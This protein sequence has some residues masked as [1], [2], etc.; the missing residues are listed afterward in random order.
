M[1]QFKIKK[2][3]DLPLAGEP[4]QRICNCVPP[5]SV[6]LVGYDYVGLK[7]TL[8]VKVGDRVKLG[9]VLFTDKK[10]PGVKYTAP[11]CG[12]VSSINRGP[13]R[14]FESIVIELDGDEEVTFPSYTTE[15]LTLLN[16]EAVVEQLVE[17]GLWTALRARPFGK[18]PQPGTSAH[19]IFITAM[20]TRPHA[21]SI[22]KIVRGNEEDFINGILAVSKL[23]D[24]RVYLCK[25]T[26]TVIPTA[27]LDR[28][29]VE[30]FSGP[31]PAG[32][33]GTHIHFL[34]PV[35]RN[36]TVWYI[37]AQDIMAIGRLFT[38]GRIPVNRV[39]AMSGPVVKEPRLIKTRLG[40]SID[41]MV[42]GELHDNDNRVISG[43]VL[44]GRTSAGAVKYLGRYHQQIS[45]V[46]EGRQRRFLGWLAPGW[47]LFSLKNIV[48]SKLVPGKRFRFTT[49][50][51]GGVRAIMPIGCYEKVMPLDILPVFL[52]RALAIDD[53]EEAE[54]LGCLELEEED[55]A[56]CT[57]ASPA[58]IDYGP[59]LRR[60]LT[61]IEKEG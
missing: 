43:S 46:E 57:F 61:I 20:D 58:K 11:G 18:V 25:K 54:K 40:A 44:D 19:S 6:A 31:H 16:R 53:I 51:N 34:D 21:P 13:K 47:D 56:L 52:L 24:G 37:G 1:G 49:A 8:A 50:L 28:L 29:S 3:L 33:A 59:V 30:E 12:R 39:I 32:N 17:S 14:V 7:P 27:D 55:L 2:G 22:E 5:K 60:N 10:T 45:V 4:E 42:H 48:F 23:T 35:H 38:T 15:Q 36:K 41:D 9:Q 26:G